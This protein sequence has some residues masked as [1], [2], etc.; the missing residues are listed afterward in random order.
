MNSIPLICHHCGQVH[1]MNR[2]SE[3]P[4][5]AQVIQCNFCMDCEDDM[6][7]YYKEWYSDEPLPEP[8]DPNQLKLEL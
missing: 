2:T 8:E 7:E 4:E 3:I 5:E 1:N 6:N